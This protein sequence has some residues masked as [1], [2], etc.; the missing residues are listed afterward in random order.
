M[1][2]VERGGKIK[3]RVIPNVKRT[4]LRPI[5]KANVRA[6]TT[7]STDELRSYKSLRELGYNH[8]SIKH[9]L[10]QYAKW[11]K[12]T[13][14]LCCTNT[15]EGYWGHLKKGIASTHVHV[16]PQHMQKYV[17]EFEF[18]FNNRKNPALMFYRMLCHLSMPQ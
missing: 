3:C 9:C 10:R 7:V 1:G 18:R 15:I 6:G 11:S 16:S 8:D 12:R 13:N 17:D 4:T 5:I 2:M 14:E